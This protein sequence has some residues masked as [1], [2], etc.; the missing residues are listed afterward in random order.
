MHELWHLKHHDHSPDFYK[1]LEC[2]LP[3]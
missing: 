2:V 1:L 3:N